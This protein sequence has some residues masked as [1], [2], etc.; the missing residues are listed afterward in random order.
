[1]GPAVRSR[2]SRV[3]GRIVY[4]SAAYV[5]R[6]NLQQVPDWA[7]VNLGARYSF[8]G[9]NKKPII[10]RAQRHQCL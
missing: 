1:M 3:L 5:D 8:D 6:A 9:I 4:D 2:A 10:V 7:Q